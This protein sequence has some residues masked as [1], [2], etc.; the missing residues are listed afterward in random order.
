MELM[1][2]HDCATFGAP[3]A[4]RASAGDTAA[5]A[6]AGADAATG[7]GAAAGGAAASGAAAD[8]AGGPSCFARKRIG[9]AA[10]DRHEWVLN[11]T[12]LH[13]PEVMLNGRPLR[14]EADEPGSLP[15]LPPVVVQM[16]EAHEQGGHDALATVSVGPFSINFFAFPN[17]Q[18][19]AC[20][21]LDDTDVD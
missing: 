10:L 14:A 17:A 9:A 21:D 13:A 5:T 4:Q 12:S 2:A 3:P 7:G 6:V 20:L 15:P 1:L 8:G 11:A 19:P 16:Q 18:L